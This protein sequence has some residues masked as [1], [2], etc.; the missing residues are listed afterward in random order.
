QIVESISGVLYMLPLG[1]ASAVALRIGKADGAEQAAR[2]RP[3][4]LAALVMAGGWMLVATG[5]LLIVGGPIAAALS[6]D[7]AV[8]TL[9][10]TLFAV[11]ALMQVF[12]G[13]QSTALGA[14]RGM[15]D[16]HW[17]AMLCLVAYWGVS[18][19]TAYVIGW[20][21]EVGPAGVWIGYGA[22]L[23]FA[24]VALSLRFWRLSGPV[25]ES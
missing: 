13:T 19:P 7:P 16:H 12:D 24:A 9:T 17:P 10:T 11:V 5:G 21:L 8:V 18:L 6:M 2:L 25:V 14:L 3:M 23:A 15:T 1:M 4:G 20:V 22:G